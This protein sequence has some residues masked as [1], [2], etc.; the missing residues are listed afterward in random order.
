MSTLPSDLLY[1][2]EHDGMVVGEHA[3]CLHGIVRD[4][5][6]T[7]HEETLALVP[8]CWPILM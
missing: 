4:L 5:V 7:P 8:D 1:T 2:K 3:V 6:N